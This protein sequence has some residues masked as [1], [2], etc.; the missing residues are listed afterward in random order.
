MF[1][2]LFTLI[3]VITTFYVVYSI[4]KSYFKFRELSQYGVKAKGVIK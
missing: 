1:Y 4:L 2:A 3:I